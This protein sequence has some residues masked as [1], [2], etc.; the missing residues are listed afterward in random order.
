MAVSR[1]QDPAT[2]AITEAAP[3]KH[4]RP[5]RRRL[6]R[7]AD[8]G[9]R[10]DAIL[11]G[12]ALMIGGVRRAFGIGQQDPAAWMWGLAAI[13]F[14][15]CCLAEWPIPKSWN[16]SAGLGGVAGEVMLAV[17]STPFAALKIP[18]PQVWASALAGLL[19]R[20]CSPQW[21]WA[22]APPTLPRCGARSPTSRN[23]ISPNPPMRPS[24]RTS[25]GVPSLPS[26]PAS[27]GYADGQRA[28]NARP[29]A[30]GSHRADRLH[31]GRRLRLRRSA[32]SS[33]PSRIPKAQ[34]ASAPIVPRVLESRPVP[35]AA[36][37]PAAPAPRQVT[38]PAAQQSS[39]RP[40][41]PP[42]AQ[43]ARVRDPNTAIPPID[44]LDVPPPRRSE[45]DEARLLEM[46][47]RLGE[48]LTEF[49]VKGRI[50]EVRP[51][52]VV[53]LFELEPAAG[54]RSS[55]VIALAEDIA[56]AMSATSARVA[57]IP[58][59]NAIG[60]ELPNPTRETVY[61]R[62]LL[63]ANEFYPLAQPPFPS[64]SASRSKASR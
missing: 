20:S 33:T 5:C 63:N 51:G 31:R 1:T 32:A 52:P 21:R 44:L 14:A 43:S 25:S 3:R 38:R 47:D 59:R 39:V 55:K 56:R 9:L 16:M 18:D 22:S 28:E 48:V 11:L 54:V 53:T 40:V 57:V 8:A 7:P 35:D 42:A 58:G 50:T 36:A 10:L 29:Q 34:M 30:A 23:A 24:A 60:I 26:R 61:L 27:N 17:V 62:D 15:A 49:G 64:P 4:V 45:V 6:R 19:A 13:L 41:Q 37:A 12:F 46:A 2:N